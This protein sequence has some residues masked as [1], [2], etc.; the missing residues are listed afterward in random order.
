MQCLSC[1]ADMQV[2]RIQQDQGMKLAGYE[3]QTLQCSGCQKTERRLEFTCD[4]ASNPEFWRATLAIDA[5]VTGGAIYQFL[6]SDGFPAPASAPNGSATISSK[7]PRN[8][9]A[10]ADARTGQPD[11]Q[12]SPDSLIG[13][14]LR[15]RRHGYEPTR[16]ASA[17]SWR[18]E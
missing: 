2:V 9:G 14:Q 16:A 6:C 3:H 13:R 12:L 5:A 1:R 15:R 4:K 10:V 17:K 7:I 8:N 11:I 18:K